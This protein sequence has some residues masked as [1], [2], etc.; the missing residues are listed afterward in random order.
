MQKIKYYDSKMY[1]AETKIKTAF[2]IMVVFLI[3]NVYRISNKSFRITKQE[4]RNKKK[5]NRN[6]EFKRNRISG[7]IRKWKM[8]KISQIG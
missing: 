2:I 7:G 6:R 1:K 3:R 4:R 8:T 5:Q